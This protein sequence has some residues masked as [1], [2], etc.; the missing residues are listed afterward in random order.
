MTTQERALAAPPRSSLIVPCLAATWLVWGSTYLAIKFALRGFPPFFQMGTR[1]LA[2]GAILLLWSVWRG[3]PLPTLS[4]WRNATIIGALM[5]GAGMGAAAYAEQTVASGL[6][7]AFIAVTPALITLVNWPFG[8]RPSRRETLGIGI[9]ILGVFLLVRGSGFAASRV[10]LVA[11]VL[12]TI[13]WSTGSVLSQQ[14]FP[15][16]RASVGFASEML[17]GGLVLLTL[18]VLSGERFHW[19]PQPAALAAWMY[20]V[21]FGSLIAFNAYML[22]LANASAALA[23]SYSFVNPVIGLVLGITLGAETVTPSEWLSVGVIV[24]GVMIV[25][26]GRSHAA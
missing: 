14:V 26:L 2:A 1:F 13:G 25:V 10:G 6:V 7:V 4:Q 5:L 22:L 18:S 21:V 19:P 23:T 3:Q 16:A 24:L 11:L 15:L 8:L 17:C 9:G 12:G 20:L